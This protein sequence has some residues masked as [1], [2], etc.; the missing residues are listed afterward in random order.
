MR[1]RLKSNA[2]SGGVE[3]CFGMGVGTKGEPR[4]K[5][6]VPRGEPTGDES[7]DEKL[8]LVGLEG[9]SGGGGASDPRLD[10]DRTLSKS[11]LRNGSGS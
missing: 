9:E 6:G 5:G 3:V 1:G 10:L 11:V 8:G 4:P 7:L 2:G